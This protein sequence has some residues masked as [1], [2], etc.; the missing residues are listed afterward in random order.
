MQKHFFCIFSALPSSICSEFVLWHPRPIFAKRFKTLFAAI[1][2][3]LGFLAFRFCPRSLSNKR[4]VINQTKH[5]R[6]KHWHLVVECFRIL[7]TDILS[8]FYECSPKLFC[9]KL[10][11]LIEIP[12]AWNFASHKALML[13]QS[14]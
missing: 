8:S 11:N 12:F 3:F 14:L 2:L 9:C 10:T 6:I 13:T 7:N 5:K 4:Y 1:K